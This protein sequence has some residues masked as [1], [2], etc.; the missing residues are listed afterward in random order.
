MSAFDALNSVGLTITVALLR[1]V[2]DLPA[3]NASDTT[4]RTLVT[5]ERARAFADFM[6]AKYDAKIRIK[7]ALPMQIAAVGFGVADLFGANGLPGGDEFLRRYATTVGAEIFI[8]AEM[9]GADTD[10][11]MVLLTHECQHVAQFRK[12]GIAFEWWYVVDQ[13]TRARYEADAY[14]GG[15]AVDH[16]LGRAL[17]E[18]IDDIAPSLAASYHLRPEDVTLARGMLA[19]HVASIADGVVN[20]DA[21]RAAI[22]WIDQRKGH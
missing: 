15:L 6:L 8:P 7:S 13:E 4:W 12:T 17:P 18:S 20:V 11:F 10:D 2:L 5:D 1:R 16:R 19:S 21:A 9:L 22:R 3:L 14:A